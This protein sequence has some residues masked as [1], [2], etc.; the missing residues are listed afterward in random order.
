MA[1]PIP[2]W[3]C[4]I[5]YI[6][7][8]LKKGSP[9]HALLSIQPFVCPAVSCSPPVLSTPKAPTGEIN[10]IV[11][12]PSGSAIQG[13]TVSVFG[14]GDRI[15]EINTVQRFRFLQFSRP[16]LLPPTG[17]PWRPA[18]FQKEIRLGIL[19]QVQQVARADFQAH[20]SELSP[21]RLKSRR[22]A[23]LLSS[24]DATVGQGDRETS[25][26]SICR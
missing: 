24:D 5:L 11:T 16:S 3:T 26:S 21:R 12:D 14:P 20:G 8:T 18:V 13:A 6:I 15:H 25:G 2:A 9:C 4:P 23:A 1:L 7:S 10:G 22:G 17:F 19:I